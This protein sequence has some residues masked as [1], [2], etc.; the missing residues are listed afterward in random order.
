MLYTMAYVSP[1]NRHR[2][3]GS[4]PASVS[5]VRPQ[6]KTSMTG[7]K[8]PRTTRYPACQ[9][10]LTASRPTGRS[11]AS[12]L[13]RDGTVPGAE[14]GHLRGRGGSVTGVAVWS[15]PRVTCSSTSGWAS[16][17][18]SCNRSPAPSVRNRR[19][20]PGPT[21]SAGGGSRHWASGS[22]PGPPPPPPRRRAVRGHRAR[23]LAAWLPAAP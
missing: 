23:T 17:L 9:P 15:A 4:G 11:G 20:W 16:G 14:T 13:D 3:S 8:P 7:A 19:T 21:R 22:P 6:C 18:C 5:T 2:R 1:G 10:A 12:R